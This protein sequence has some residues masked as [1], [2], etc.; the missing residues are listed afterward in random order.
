MTMILFV[1]KKALAVRATTGRAMTGKPPM[2]RVT[3]RHEEYS[4]NHL[5]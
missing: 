5:P 2:E 3:A 4:G 1:T